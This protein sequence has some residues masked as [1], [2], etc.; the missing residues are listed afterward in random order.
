ML[1]RHEDRL[2]QLERELSQERFE[3]QKLDFIVKCL[4]LGMEMEPGPSNQM[5]PVSPG[6]DQAAPEF[7][8]RGRGFQFKYLRVRR[9]LT[10]L[11]V[12]NQVMARL[13]FSNRPIP[14]S[15]SFFYFEMRII[16][17]GETGIIGIGLVPKSNGMNVC[18]MPGWHAGYGYHGDDGAK[19]SSATN[20]KGGIY[21]PT[22]HAG[23]V[24]GCGFDQEKGEIFFTKN[25]SFLGI[26]FSNVRP[27]PNLHP[28]VGFRSHGSE[29]SVNFGQWEFMYDLMHWF[30]SRGQ[31]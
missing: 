18:Q 6:T 27:D 8:E 16:N 28:V 24:V 30:S 5:I 31:Q 14:M 26:A 21:G 11:G 13:V 2:S 23:D 12:L 20:G 7:D 19:F 17:G 1:Q 9:N 25:G 3:R 29:V 4:R 22:F 15:M 10:R